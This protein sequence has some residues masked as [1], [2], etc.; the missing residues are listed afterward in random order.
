MSISREF[1]DYV[2]D[3]G[4]TISAEVEQPGACEIYVAEAPGA[5][6]ESAQR[7]IELIMRS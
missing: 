1:D 4:I 7:A 6:L 2:A 3:K 5:E